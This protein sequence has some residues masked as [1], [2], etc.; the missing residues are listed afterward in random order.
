MRKISL[1][2]F[3]L[4][5]VLLV[6]GQIVCGQNLYIEIL[7]VANYRSLANVRVELKS[8]QANITFYSS[9]RGEVIE[10]VPAGFYSVTF[11]RSAYETQYLEE[12]EIKSQEV[13]SLSI[14][15][16][17]D[18][19]PPSG[20]EAYEE[21]QVK[22]PDDS[23]IPISI[24][25]PANKAFVDAF[26]QTG[27]IQ[28]LQAGFGLFIFRELY[29]KITYSYSRQTYASNFFE[30]T[31]DYSLSFS[32]LSFALGYEYGYPITNSFGI[33]IN[34]E[35]HL[36]ME[37]LN[38][39]SAIGQENVS[40]IMNP[41]FRP[42]VTAGLYYNSLSLFAGFNYSQWISQPMTHERYGLYDNDSDLPL[43]WNEDLFPGRKGLGILLG[44]RLGF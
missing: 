19:S 37:F 20:R 36:G 40:Y 35:I 22:I 12:V 10:Y 41:L 8:A 5:A 31:Q 44:I 21:R 3:Y 32:N 11:S 24:K 2:P 17:A 7:D 33:L 9:P 27:N 34:P 29:S 38:S 28:S 25:R 14:F 16:R 39:Q 4:M 30:T 15:M 13:T 18:A 43:S 1:I 6:S 26:L 23:D 42:G